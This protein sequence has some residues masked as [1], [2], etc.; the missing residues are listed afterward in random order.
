MGMGFLDNLWQDVQFGARLLRLNKAFFLVAAFSLALGIGANTAI[1]QLLDAV[2]LRTLPVSHPEQLVQLQIGKDEHCCSGDFVDRHPDFT[3]A[4]WEQIRDRQQAFSS[5]FAFGDN[6]FNLSGRG[7]VH[8]AEGLWVTGD[9]FKALGVTPLLGRLISAGDDQLGCG[10][11]G[12]VISYSFWQRQFGGDP[13]IVGKQISLDSHRLDIIGVTPAD[14]FGVEVGRNFDVAAPACA[15][16]LIDGLN[17]HLAKRHHWWL[18]VIGR[19][20]P[21][22]TVT[23]AAA[24]AAAISRQVFGNTVPP[25]YRPDAVKYYER[26]K[27]IALPAGAGVSDLRRRYQEPLLLL[28]AIAGLVL[29]IACSNLA[30][31]ML[32]RASTRE[33]EMAV[34]LAIGASRSRLIRQMLVES[35]LLAV[36]GAALGALIAQFLSRYLVAFLTTTYDPLFLSFAPDWRVFGFTCALAVLTCILFG[37]TPALRATRTAPASAMKTSS[38][39]VTADRQ[40]FGLGRTLVV[41]QVAL[42]LVLLVAALLFVRSLRYLMTLDAGFQ[43]EGLLI[44]SVDTGNLSLPFERRMALYRDVLGRLRSAPGIEQAASAFIVPISGAGWNDAIE[45][46]GQRSSKR[47]IPWFDSLSDGYFRTMGTPLLAGRDFNDRDT[48][49]SPYVAIVNQEFSKKFLNGANP[50]GK[51]FRTLAG[52]GEQQKV[53]QVVGLVKNSKYQNLQ[54]EFVPTVFV[55]QEQTN[56]PFTGVNYIVRS[57]AATGPLMNEIKRSLLAVNPNLSMVFTVF[58]T[59]VRESLVRER[60]MATLSGFFGFLAVLL[61]TVGLYGVISYMVARRQNEIGIRI[62]LGANRSTILNLVIREAGVLLGLGLVIGIALALATARAAASFLFGLKPTDPASI[63]S[64]V[65]LLAVVALAASLLPALR[66][67]R[68]EPMAALREE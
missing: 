17:S 13:R 48:A 35:F 21:G 22:W 65:A 38:R 27:L 68:V 42:S 49:G 3:F 62:A 12:V 46:L 57:S 25:N 59:Q 37:L 52:P 8:F 41:T 9:F 18:A 56:T 19:L 14:F 36:V 53:Y 1:F 4:Q 5:V 6:R 16:P 61:A 67:S 11:P 44:I 10:S 7:E 30:N 15:E 64:A 45:I 63:G 2:R 31:L 20:K 58:K 40:R 51:Q 55:A 66:A 43:Q 32:A 29:L 47:L 28:L 23:R 33:R 34:R 50:I 24:Q 60:L 26:Y 54:D 39:G